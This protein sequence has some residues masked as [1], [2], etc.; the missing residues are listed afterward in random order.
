MSF[1][2][3]HELSSE[4]HV[5]DRSVRRL[6]KDGLI[7]VYR[8]S[9]KLLRFKMDEVSLALS[10]VRIPARSEAKINGGEKI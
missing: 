4:L 10:R 2:T 5:S 1:Y 7:P 3:I 9:S 6:V 8:V